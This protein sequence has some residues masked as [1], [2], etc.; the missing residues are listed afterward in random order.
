MATSLRSRRSFIQ[1]VGLNG[2]AAAA[3]SSAPASSASAEKIGPRLISRAAAPGAM[4]RLDSN[5]NSSGPGPRVLAAIQDAFGEI[6]RYPFAAS[7]ELSAAIAGSL[8]VPPDQ[9]ELGAGSSEILDVAV[10]TFTAPDRALVTA[11]PTFEMPANLAHYLGHPVIEVPVTDGLA[12]D[13]DQ[14]AARATGA[15]LLYACNPNNPT[16]TLHGASAIEQFVGDVLKREPTATILIDEAYH[17]YVERAD[18]RTAV[19]LALSN[20]RVIVS[21]TFSKIFGLAGMRIGYAVG[22]RQTLSGLSKRLDALRISRL[23]TTAALTALADP[24]RI[25]EQRAANHD[26]RAFT[27]RTFKDAGY[28][29][30]A[31]EANFLMVNVRRDIR[32]FQAACHERGVGV[33]RPFPPLTTYAR[34]TI[35]TIE[36]MKRAATVFQEVL[37]QPVSAARLEPLRREFR[38]RDA[39]DWAC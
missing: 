1:F 22:Q 9:I 18:Y 8:G 24:S 20:P 21:R 35:G 14:M 16:A 6:N 33:A 19:P 17:E 26:A 32:A 15:G 38:R 25:A 39:R 4:L 34:V 13:L 5:E 30:V 7:Q 27:A 31:S 28:E 29:P 37:A 12:L 10:S 23:S 2:L 36:E 3:G 11:A